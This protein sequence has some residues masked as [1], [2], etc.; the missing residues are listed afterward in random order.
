M[1]F[2]EFE[3]LL[4]ESCQKNSISPLTNEQ[5]DLFW[6]FTDHLTTVNAVTNLTAIRNVPDIIVKHYADSLT[7]SPLIPQGSR[8]LDLGC[9]PGFPSIPLAIARPDLS[10]VALDSTEKKIRFVNESAELLGLNNL[11]GVSGRAEDAKTR[12]LLKKFDC[13]VSRA[14]SRLNLL[15]ELCIPYLNIG[16]IFIAMKGSKGEEELSEAQK[17]IAILGGSLANLHSF[18]LIDQNGNKEGR[19]LIEIKKI[20][21]TP[22]TYPRAYSTIQKKPL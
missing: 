15:D 9:G 18:F 7:A 4:T 14:V 8:V 5:I 11:R 21:E 12:N 10:I 19:C 17:G 16:G 22:A 6:R 3:A 2:S 13:V 1:D 20:Q